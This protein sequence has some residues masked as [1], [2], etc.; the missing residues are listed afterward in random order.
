[1]QTLTPR[2]LIID[3]DL[4]NA[5]LIKLLLQY[6]DTA[7]DITS[8]Q[9]PEAGLR[10]A[11]T[12]N[13][14]LFLLDYRLPSMSGAEVCR[15]IRRTNADT[16]VLFFTGSAFERDRWDA[17]QAGANAYLLKPDDLKQLTGTVKRLIGGSIATYA[18]DR[19]LAAPLSD[20]S[21]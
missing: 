8:V 11:A 10:L 4:D 12:Q 16:P 20:A 9:T 3:D 5:E 19:S 6:S 17:M 13:F 1:M 2:I 15:R 14:D 18:E 21:R 7:C